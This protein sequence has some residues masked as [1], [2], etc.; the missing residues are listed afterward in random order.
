MHAWLGSEG[1]FNH[2]WHPGTLYLLLHM[3]ILFLFC[4][5]N[6]SPL[7]RAKQKKPIICLKSTRT[8]NHIGVFEYKNCINIGRFLLIT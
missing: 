1:Y 4:F 8:E 5:F 7:L 3:S 6:S 2:L